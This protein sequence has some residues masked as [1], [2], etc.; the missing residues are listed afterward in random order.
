MPVVRRNCSNTGNWLRTA[1]AV[2]SITIT[3]STRRSVS[4]VPNDFENDTP[5]HFLSVPQR[6]T[7]P[8]RGTTK[9]EAYDKKMASTQTRA[10]V[11]SP[12][13]FKAM[14]HRQARK[15]WGKMP[16]T[17]DKAIHPQCISR[18]T[19]CRKS[20]Q[21]VPRYIHHKMPIPSTKGRSVFSM[22]ISIFLTFAFR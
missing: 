9:L 14:R 17:N 1:T 19:Q 13:G 21:S 2:S 8:M 20:R 12:K 18:E 5:S 10:R 4:T 6:A 7:S 3:E 22:L 16:N 15:S 11:C